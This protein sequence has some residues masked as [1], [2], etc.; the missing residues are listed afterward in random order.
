[1]WHGA[2]FV[3]TK[4]YG[5]HMKEEVFLRHCKSYVQD[6]FNLNLDVHP[7]SLDRRTLSPNVHTVS[8]LRWPQQ[9]SETE[10]YILV[11][12]AGTPYQHVKIV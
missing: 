1:M 11:K 2:S 7:E 6:F 3:L 4:R 12:V 10:G 8:V 9:K 5:W